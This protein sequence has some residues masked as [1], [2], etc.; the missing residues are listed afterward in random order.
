M[1]SPQSQTLF[2]QAEDQLKSAQASFDA[3]QY[4][5][6]EKLA[7]RASEII[8]AAY[9]AKFFDTAIVPSEKA[10][11]VFVDKI[12]AAGT[13]P[14]AIQ[15]IRGVVGDTVVLREAFE[16]K[17]LNE[18]TKIDAEMILLRVDA[19]LKIATSL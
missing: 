18:T 2:A 14:E 3:S 5:E 13:T 10:F 9:L 4:G 11:Q 6:C 17:L 19:L 12:W 8:A 1:T 7:Y 15:E 16:P